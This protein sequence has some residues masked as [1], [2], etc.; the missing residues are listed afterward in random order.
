MSGKQNYDILATLQEMRNDYWRN[1]EDSERDQSLVGSEYLVVQLGSRRCALPAELCSEVLKLPRLV[2]V[3]R[4]PAHFRG[5]FNL[6][7]EILAVTDLSI[8]FDQARQE[9]TPA[10]RL[11]VVAHD[12]IKTALLVTRVEGLQRIETERI[13]PLADGVAARWRDLFAGKQ[14][15]EEASLMVIDLKS[16]LSRPEL[17]VDQKS[18]DT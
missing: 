16:V 18:L 3:P 7:G 8:L 13:E 4:L 12:S 11:V 14:V 5:I 1:L 2:R 15:E 6:R 17:L 9:T 10:C